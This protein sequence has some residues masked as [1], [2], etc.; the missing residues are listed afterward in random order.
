MDGD[1]AFLIARAL[2][3]LPSCTSYICR[4]LDEAQAYLS[5]AGVYHDAA[6]YPPAAAILTELR[7]G[8]HSAYDLLEW[9]RPHEHL[10]ALPV[11]ILSDAISPQ[12]MDNLKHLGA[13]A[14]FEKPADT[15]ELRAT[16]AAIAEKVCGAD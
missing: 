1:D 14:I 6:K 9:M 13:A 12:D 11:Y 15:G 3:T 8:L 10:R 16:L 4:S 5:K 2:N 7:L